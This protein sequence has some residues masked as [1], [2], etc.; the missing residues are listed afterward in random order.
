MNQDSITYL[1]SMFAIKHRDNLEKLMCEIDLHSGQIFVLNS[2]WNSDGQSQAE[3]AKGLSLSAPTIYN[4]V[5]RMADKGLVA[6]RKD[7]N[8]ARIM[9][10]FLTDFGLEIKPKVEE[11]W[12]KFEENTLKNLTEPEKMMFSLLLQKV[13]SNVEQ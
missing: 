7:P 10:V 8:D 5:S 6:I 1:F 4:M 3:L 11:Q 13:L 9:R 12:Q 2:L